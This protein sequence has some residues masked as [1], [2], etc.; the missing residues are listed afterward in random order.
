VGNSDIA[1]FS[2]GKPSSKL[3]LYLADCMSNQELENIEKTW[4]IHVVLFGGDENFI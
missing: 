1:L 3:I 2:I 4:E